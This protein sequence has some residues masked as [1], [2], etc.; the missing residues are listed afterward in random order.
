M[1]GLAAAWSLPTMQ[2]VSEHPAAIPRSYHKCRIRSRHRYRS[3]HRISISQPACMD[4]LPAWSDCLHGKTSGSDHAA[5]SQRKSLKS[6][7]AAA[8]FLGFELFS[9][10]TRKITW[11]TSKGKTFKQRTAGWELAVSPDSIRMANRLCAKGFC[12]KKLNP[13]SY[14][15]LTGFE[16][17]IIIER[18]NAVMRGY[19]EYYTDFITNK[20]SLNRWMYII[21][22]SCLK[23]LAQKYNTT[24]KK[25][26]KRFPDPSSSINN[27]SIKYVIETI[28]KNGNK[29]PLYKTWS[30][31]TQKEVINLTNKQRNIIISRKLRRISLGEVI[32]EAHSSNRTPRIMD[33]DFTDRLNWVNL[34]TR[35]SFDMPCIQCGATENIEMHHVKAI[36][37]SRYS[38]INPKDTIKRMLVLRN[39]KQVPLCDKCHQQYHKDPSSH[40]FIKASIP[41]KLVDNRI[42]NIEN[43]IKKGSPHIS[44]PAPDSFYEK[45]WKDN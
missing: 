45:G 19:G 35:A 14:G 25:L 7:H 6:F 9:R 16:P 33:A 15:F 10:V 1:L 22:W 36:R 17:H 44:L 27:V 41:I 31:L 2:A 34:R 23:T 39:R 20:S 18:F 32:Y 28:D 5:A 4:G 38:L 40:R 3:R 29:L 13:K 37:K 43:Y 11:V 12:D 24:I 42:I 8:R 21:R 26:F 30:L